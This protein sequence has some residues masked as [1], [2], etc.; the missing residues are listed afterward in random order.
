M[1]Q[2]RVKLQN[3]SKIVIYNFLFVKERFKK[4]YFIR[5]FHK[6]LDT[7]HKYQIEIFINYK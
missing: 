4:K 2:W 7:N 5:T 1:E 6:I 3:A